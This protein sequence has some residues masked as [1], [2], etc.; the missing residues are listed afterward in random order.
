[1]QSISVFLDI[2][3]FADLLWR[4]LCQQNSKGVSCDSHMF[5]ILFRYVIT[6]PSFMIIGYV[7]QILGTIMWASVSS[8][9]KTH[10]EIGLTVPFEK[11]KNVSFASSVKKNICV[12][13]TRFRFRLKLICCSAFGSA[14]NFLLF[15]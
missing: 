8:H 5:W 7:W 13:L 15:T 2:A 3:K 11:S 10:P 9:E 4:M 6:V 12:V 1:M 14:S